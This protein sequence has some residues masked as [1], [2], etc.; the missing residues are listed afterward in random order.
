VGTGVI[1]RTCGGSLRFIIAFP[2][3]PWR[4]PWAAV[5]P[6]ERWKL[7]T[8]AGLGCLVPKSGLLTR[9]YAVAKT[10]QDRGTATQYQFPGLRLGAEGGLCVAQATPTWIQQPE[11]PT[12]VWGTG[13]RVDSGTLHL[14]FGRLGDEALYRPIRFA[15]VITALMIRLG[16][17]HVVQ[18][19]LPN[20]VLRLFWRQRN[21]VRVW[22][23]L[24][25]I[26]DGCLYVYAD[27]NFTIV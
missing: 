21:G 5:L 11:P 4:F 27:T 3:L 2:R 20:W 15:F 10:S 14:T 16:N 26:V 17:L 1:Q 12:A 9:H 22:L 19:T 13:I 8:K 6:Q 18:F 7:T 23:N 24:D 25:E